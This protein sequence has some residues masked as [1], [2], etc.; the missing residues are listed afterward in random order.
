L[1]SAL[2][3]EAGNRALATVSVVG[4]PKPPHVPEFC[5]ECGSRW[6]AEEFGFNPEARFIDLVCTAKHERR[7]HLS[8]QEMQDFLRAVAPWTQGKPTLFVGGPLDGYSHT[9]PSTTQSWTV[10]TE[11]GHEY[12]FRDEQPEHFVYVW[13]GKDLT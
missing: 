9:F 2:T 12:R 10:R 6:T 3:S 11:G 5:P 8:E 7:F 4:S 13:K 1:P